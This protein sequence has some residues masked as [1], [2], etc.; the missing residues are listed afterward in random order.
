MK[1]ERMSTKIAQMN[2]KNARRTKNERMSTKCMDEYK[3]E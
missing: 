2:S 3:N 1:N